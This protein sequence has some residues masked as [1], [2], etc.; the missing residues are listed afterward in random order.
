MTDKLQE[1]PVPKPLSLSRLP[2]VRREDLDERGR[3]AYDSCADP[4]SRLFAKLVGPPGFWLH[5]PEMLEPIRELNWHLR[6]AD[7]GLERPLREL[8]ILV[9]ARENDAQYEWSAHEPYALEAGLSPATI[10]IVKQHGSI[11]ALA[12]KEAAI[13][14]FGRQ[15]FREKNVDS[16]TYDRAIQALGQRGVVHM[17]ALMSNYTMTAVIFHSIDQKLRPGQVALLPIP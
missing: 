14:A 17:I 1:P 3:K 5:I 6:N 9:T 13:I 10:E 12:A 7:I 16:Q 15:L 2:A 8:T 11:D 4:G